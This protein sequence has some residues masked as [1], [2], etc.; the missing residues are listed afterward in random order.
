MDV[1]MLDLQ[2][3]YAAVRDELLAAVTEAL[4]VQPVCNGP[5]VR[6]LERQIA[7]YSTAASA[8]A[9]SSGTD[10]LLCSLMAMEIGPGDEVIVPP[11]TFFATAGCVW[12]A[13]AR[14]VF[15]DIE[16]DT[17]NLDP[18]AI[19]QAITDRTKAIMPVH[20]YGQV[21]EMDSILA[22]AES[23]GLYVIEDAAQ[24][25]GAEYKGRKAGSMGAVG[26]LSF[27]P[28]K[29]LGAVGDGGMI[30]TQ[31]A[32]LAEK[33]E[34]LRNHGQSRTYYH[35][36]VGGNFRMDSVQAAALSVKLRH[37]DDWSA[38]RRENARR[39]DELLSD[40][41]G[42]VTPKVRKDNVSIFNQYVIRTPRRDEL[43]AFLKDSGIAT[44]VYYPL[45]LHEQPCFRD[46]G[47]KSGDFPESEKAAR[48]VLALPVFP[49]LT[50]EQIE[51]VAR[52]IRE[53]T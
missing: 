16:P 52:K 45:G 48:E 39:Y 51:Y 4:D 36:W 43:R 23:R 27:Y 13:G 9:V 7:E 38:K 40:C 3:Q 28:T 12:R 37:L 34:K 25:I 31:D 49:E 6:R 30:L 10:A 46:L 14:P 29:N 11:F 47:Y 22:V 24:A 35:D 42:V 41:D 50:D 8:V 5:A 18:G 15:V 21:A 19:E 1:P 26:C 2:A 32:A 33:L 20:L 17:F 53:F 44:G